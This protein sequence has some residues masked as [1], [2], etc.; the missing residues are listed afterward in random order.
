M[1]DGPKTIPA[2]ERLLFLR[3]VP[4]FSDLVPSDLE[5]VEAITEER[6][7]ADGETIAAQGELGHE[8]HVVTE[9][10]IR[11]IREHDGKE[12]EVARRLTGDVVGEMSIIAGAPRIASLV[13]E[14]AVRTLRIGYREFESML[15]ERPDVALGVMR[16]LA[17]RLTEATST[18]DDE[19]S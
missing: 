5:Q 8:M 11:V 9:G 1:S 3:R 2:I 17:S 16:V 19:L 14:G 13:A 18:R 12:R 15:R 6:G 7:Y 4:L 10:V